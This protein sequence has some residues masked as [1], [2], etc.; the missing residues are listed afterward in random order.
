VQRCR[1]LGAQNAVRTA[2]TPI[3]SA[4]SSRQ[5][6]APALKPALPNFLYEHTESIDSTNAELLRRAGQG[7]PIHLRA[8]CADAQTAGRGQRGRVWRAAKGGAL[9]LSVGWHFQKTQSLSGLSLAVGVCVANCLGE[10]IEN[11]D[12]VSLKWPNDILLSQVTGDSSPGKA[13]GILIE[14]VSVDGESRAAVIGIGINLAPPSV[15]PDNSASNAFSSLAPAALWQVSTVTRLALIDAL[16]PALA[17]TLTQFAA[18]GFVPFKSLWWER[19]AYANNPNSE[20]SAV[21]VRTPR[22]ESLVGQMVEITDSGA[23]V[24]EAG[25]GRHTLVSGQVSLRRNDDARA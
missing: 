20:N 4:T 10:L 12:L 18:D 7:Q 23:L 3:H 6:F 16:L 9:L 24:I 17:Q 1:R 11:S 14:T 8:L 22:G 25:G 2:T 21:I 13:G 15:V 19:R 5:K